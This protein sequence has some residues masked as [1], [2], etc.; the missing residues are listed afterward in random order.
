MRPLQVCFAERLRRLPSAP[1][2]CGGQLLARRFQALLVPSPSRWAAQPCSQP[3]SSCTSKWRRMPPARLPSRR[4][5]ARDEADELWSC[6]LTSELT[7]AHGRSAHSA[8]RKVC[9]RVE[10][11]VR[12]HQRS[13]CHRGS[14][15]LHPG[16]TGCTTSCAPARKKQDPVDTQSLRLLDCSLPNARESRV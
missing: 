8:R 16:G 4:P 3:C 11:P 12:A 5:R 14:Q 13:L 10:R 2:R 6:A 7:G 9:V 1:T 15:H